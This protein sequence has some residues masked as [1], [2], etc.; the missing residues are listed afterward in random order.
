[1]ALQTIR[2]TWSRCRAA[3]TPA[4]VLIVHLQGHR[5]HLLLLRNPVRPIR[6]TVR[7]S[8]KSMG[9]RRLLKLTLIPV[10]MMTDHLVRGH[11]KPIR[12]RQTLNRRSHQRYSQVR[13]CNQLYQ[14]W[15][16][17]A[18]VRM[19]HR[20]KAFNATFARSGILR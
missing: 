17:S 20:I 5:P 6:R 14:Q 15:T 4:T 16:V 19:S 2:T 3:E 8:P 11:T 7:L 18:R 1:M 13:Q 12:T 10:L 9:T